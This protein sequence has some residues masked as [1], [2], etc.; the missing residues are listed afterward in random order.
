MD[1]VR[2]PNI[3]VCYTPSSEP[4]SIYFYVCITNFVIVVPEHADLMPSKNGQLTETCK[5]NKYIQTESHWTVLTII[6]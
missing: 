6:L 4:Y 3:S 2:K 1:K 5:G